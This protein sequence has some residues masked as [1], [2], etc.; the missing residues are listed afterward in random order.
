MNTNERKIITYA[1]KRAAMHGWHL[2]RVRV[3]YDPQDDI[4]VDTSDIKRAL[5]AADLSDDS[6]L[7]F[8]APD[9]RKGWVRFIFGNGNRG[10]DVAADASGNLAVVYDDICVYS[11]TL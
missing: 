4:R 1:I 3:S 9:G 8:V 2:T 7:V 10:R 5:E 11:E 6:I